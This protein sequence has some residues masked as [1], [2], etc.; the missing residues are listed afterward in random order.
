MSVVISDHVG[1]NPCDKGVCA[2]RIAPA[3]QVCGFPTASA[4]L[5]LQ[6]VWWPLSWNKAGHKQRQLC[7]C[8]RN[9]ARGRRH[10]SSGVGHRPDLGSAQRPRL[11]VTSSATAA[12]APTVDGHCR[13][14]G[15]THDLSSGATL[16]AIRSSL[17]SPRGDRWAGCSGGVGHCYASLFAMQCWKSRFELSYRSLIGAGMRGLPSFRTGTSLTPPFLVGTKPDLIPVGPLQGLSRKIDDEAGFRHG[18]H[19]DRRTGSP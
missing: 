17:S 14:C 6:P 11:Y 8:R 4:E 9:L 10:Q 16:A 1:P 5:T 18:W 19:R 12:Y 13:L 7:A 2:Y 3:P 15:G